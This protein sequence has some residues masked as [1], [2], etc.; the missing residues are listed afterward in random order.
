MIVIWS[1]LYIVAYLVAFVI[2]FIIS[3]I[4][5]G[6]LFTF[7]GGKKHIVIKPNSISIYNKKLIIFFLFVSIGLPYFFFG[8][9]LNYP[10]PFIT[11]RTE[12]ISS[13][14]V[15]K[16]LIEL[17]EKEKYIQNTISNMDNLTIKQISTELSKVLEY[18][19]E[20][21]NEAINQQTIVEQLKITGID[22]KNKTDNLIKKSKEVEQLTKP[23]LEAIKYIITEDAAKQNTKSF[24]FGILISFPIG[25]FASLFANIFWKKVYHRK[26]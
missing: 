12:V 9:I 23:Q 18:V 4:S 22:E 14:N 8:K 25:V 11:T 20:L 6:G 10:P 15:D 1:I 17:A 21:K 24:W 16:R 5:L 7:F 26:I 19:I 3:T 2:F 13:N